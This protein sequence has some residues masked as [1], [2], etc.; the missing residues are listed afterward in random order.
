M[1]RVAEPHKLNT[2]RLIGRRMSRRRRDLGLSQE[3]LATRCGLHPSIIG[4]IERGDR[5]P[6]ILTVSTVAA[7]LGVGVDD[8]LHDIEIGTESQPVG[9]LRVKQEQRPSAAT[10]APGF[11]VPP[12]YEMLTDACAVFLDDH[13]DYTHNVFIM[14]GIGRDQ[15][16]VRLDR[17]LRSALREHGLNPVRADDRVYTPD[18]S[19]WHNLCVYMI[20]C[21]MGIAAFEDGADEEL[22]PNVTLEYGFMRALNKPTLLLVEKNLRRLR[23]DLA[24]TLYEP[25]D[26]ANIET[27]RPAVAKWI[28]DLGSTESAQD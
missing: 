12:G 11:V 23:S 21:G 27:V 18:R 6:P 15:R 16:R 24:G 3:D 28:R 8:L 22:N 20:C 1:P 10:G 14:T 19:L 17:E 2:L 7:S 5:N 25:F 9:T 4:G 26:L 13:P